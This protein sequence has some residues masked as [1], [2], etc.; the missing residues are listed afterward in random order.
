MKIIRNW[1]DSN[2][3]MLNLSKSK[4]ICLVMI[5]LSMPL[6][7]SYVSVMSN[8]L[9]KL[10]ICLKMEKINC[11]KYPGNF[12]DDNLKYILHIDHIY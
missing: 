4:Y 3:S 5:R 10:C 9:I 11:V 8:V 2:S 7:L 12:I 1:F 6:S